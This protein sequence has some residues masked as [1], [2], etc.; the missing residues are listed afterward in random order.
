MLYRIDM[1]V[2]GVTREIVV[3]ANGMFPT[4]PLPDAAF[5]FGGTAVGNS[6]ADRMRR[7]NADLISRQRVAKFASP[8]GMVHMMC[9]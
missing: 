1:N 4:A 6:F 9:R 8:S 7:E 5:A 2:V 3:V